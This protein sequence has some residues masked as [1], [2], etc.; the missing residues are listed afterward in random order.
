MPDFP[1]IPETITVHLGRPDDPAPNVTVPF[2]EYI[3][4]VAS[5]ELYPT[6]PENALRANIYAEISFALN[7]IYTEWYRSRGY[8]FDITNS[9]A[10]D[11]A[12]VNNRDIF[13]NV[14]NIVNEIFDQYLARPGY[15]QPL[16]AAYCDGRRV[17]CEGLSQW[18]TVDLA[19]QGMTP[20]EILTHYYGDNLDIRT[21]P[22]RPL[23]QSYP[24]HPLRLGDVE[25]GVEI[26]QQRLNRIS[27]N[28]PAIPKIYPVNGVFDLNTENAVK[29]FQRI[30]NLTPDGIVG[31]ATWYQITSVY[32]AVLRLAEPN[33]EGVTLQ[34]VSREL[35]YT[36]SE[37]MR[38]DA[39]RLLQFFLSAVGLYNDEV[40]VIAVDGIFGPDTKN[41]VI[42]F[43]NYAGLTPDGIVGANTWS[44]LLNAYE[45][46]KWQQPPNDGRAVVPP[47]T[48]TLVLGSRSE[49][50][51]RLQGWLNR[52]AE[53]YPQITPIP[54][55]GYYGEMTRDAVMAFQQL[56]GLPVTGNVNPLVF[57]Y[58]GLTANNMNNAGQ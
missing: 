13:G 33:A 39:I 45:E 25:V 55:T 10:Y 21:A 11:Q 17:Q 50:V 26:M 30:F 15:V 43:Q 32:N 34:D 42:A 8:D 5:S 7:R 22:I 36:L 3:Q 29:E 31:P 41:A 12:F 47:P 14:A 51:S 19:E 40:P 20:Y 38:G 57:Y 18:G 37:G 28:Y 44:A 46:I 4:N 2:L 56:F 24:G 49:D 23:I 6:W 54:Q 53:E 35:P 9:T 27:N 52:I 48:Q 1:Y 16:F 58:I